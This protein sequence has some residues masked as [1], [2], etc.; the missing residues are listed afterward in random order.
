MNN[1]IDGLADNTKFNDGLRVY[2]NISNYES[3]SIFP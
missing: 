1:L 2:K 3:K